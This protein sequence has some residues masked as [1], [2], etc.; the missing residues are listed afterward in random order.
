MSGSGKTTLA[1]QVVHRLRSAGETWLLVDGDR[2]RAIMGEDLGHT[3]DDRRR[4]SER[5]MNLSRE[6]AA[7]RLN[8]VVCILSIFPDH[9]ALNREQ[10]P[11]YREVYLKVPFETLLARDNKQ[12]YR[13]A[14]AGEQKSVVGVDIPF[15][16]PPAPDVVLENSTPL[17]SLEP[18][19]RDMLQKLGLPLV[20]YRYAAED[21]LAAP[22]KYAYTPFFGR[23]FL[24]AYE[25]SREQAMANLSSRLDRLARAFAPVEPPAALRDLLPRRPGLSS[26]FWEQDLQPRGNGASTRLDTKELLLALLHEHD[27]DEIAATRFSRLL[28][29]FEV[30]KRLY[31]AYDAATF[32]VADGDYANM[33]LYSLFGLVLI[34]RARAERSPQR[35]AILLNAMLKN[36]DILASALHRYAL[37]VEEWSAH[38][39]LE[40]ELALLRDYRRS[41]GL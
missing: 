5:M 35:R 21:R 34:R 11:D 20:A 10:I 25:Q 1:R 27:L 6:F 39:A 29:R 37:P 8:A 18:L 38:A 33:L 24:D 13:R 7:Q 32:K 19:A 2:F 41:H 14:L 28:H 40:G 12:L 17:D 9:Q 31:A 30:S 26:T 16:E 36:G 4:M 22:E 15:P 3:I 23:D